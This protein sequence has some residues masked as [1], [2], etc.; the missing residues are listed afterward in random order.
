[1]RTRLRHPWPG[2][3][4]AGRKPSTRFPRSREI[5]RCGNVVQGMNVVRDGRDD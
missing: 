3:S 1:M 5:P 4:M 2:L